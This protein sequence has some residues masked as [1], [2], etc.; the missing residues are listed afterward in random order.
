MSSHRFEARYLNILRLLVM[1]NANDSTER[2]LTEAYELG[3]EML[4]SDIPPD[5]LIAIHQQ[6]VL[7]LG[8]QYPSLTLL[9][10]APSINKPLMETSMAYGLGFREQMQTRYQTMLND[11]VAQASKLEALGIM[12]AG[13]A[14]DFNN[15]LG[16]ILGF[17]ELVND[18]VIPTTKADHNLHQIINSCLRA[19][20]IVRRMLIF[21]Q[22]GQEQAQALDII[23][24][25]RDILALLSDSYRNSVLFNITFN[26]PHA[27]VLIAP[28]KW[29]QLLI[30]LCV[31]AIESF[32]EMACGHVDISLDSASETNGKHWV[33]LQIADN[34]RGMPPE[35]KAH[36]FDPF[37]TTKSESHGCGL[38]LSVVYGIVT[39]LG[40]YIE[41][42]SIVS[43]NDHGTQFRVYLP[44]LSEQASRIEEASPL[45]VFAQDNSQD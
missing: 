13:I 4:A 2:L 45:S 10:V 11:Q 18:D 23:E 43:G 15:I 14:H 26:I 21:A 34:G 25:T 29:Q 35:V 9:Q 22:Q 40:G 20:D 36:A 44:L 32:D 41:V 28:G 1:T 12:A 16:S 31:N 37:F 30:N 33:C 6:A 17:A 19:R 5:E 42:S 3:R 24:Q 27:N 39:E 38:G 8:Q 7:S